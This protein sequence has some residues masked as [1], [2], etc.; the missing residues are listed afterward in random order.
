M[1]LN[2]VS[3]NTNGRPRH[4]RFMVGLLFITV[5][6]VAFGVWSIRSKPLSER[7]RT[8]LSSCQQSSSTRYVTCIKRSAWLRTLILA[9]G[10]DEVM[11][12]LSAVYEKEPAIAFNDVASCHEVAHAVGEVAVELTRDVGGTIARCTAH[13]RYGCVH[14]A[15]AKGVAIERGNIS[16]LSDVC[17][18]IPY[19]AIGI[20]KEEACWH[21]VGHGFADYTGRNLPQALTLCEI[22]PNEAAHADCGRGVFMEVVDFAS[23]SELDLIFQSE[24]TICGKL[25]VPF[26]ERCYSHAAQFAFMTSRSIEQAVSVCKGAPQAFRQECTLFI[27][28]ALHRTYR[29]KPDRIIQACSATTEPT[30]CLAGV[31]HES[32]LT[33]PEALVAFRLCSMLPD[34]QKSVCFATLGGKIEESRGRLQR[35]TLCNTVPSEYRKDCS[36]NGNDTVGLN[37]G[38]R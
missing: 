2:K 29:D 35:H 31:I 33:D 15:L 13:C 32:V 5:F 25:P 14:G 18:R 22:L 9:F 17:T 11:K 20:T 36:G 30:W 8:V 26:Q 38:K 34:D 21:G 1:S 10:V 4:V 3:I 16:A 28:Y 37:T 6:G 12:A 24:G 19:A 27:G 7:I 23:E